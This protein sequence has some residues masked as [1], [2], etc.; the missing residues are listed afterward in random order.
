MELIKNT[1]NI[2]RIPAKGTT[3]TMVDSDVIVPDVKPDILKIL[4]V[5]A[6]CCVTDTYIENG[7]LIING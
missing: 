7:K 6:D 2:C 4:Q 1:V 3:K 5:D